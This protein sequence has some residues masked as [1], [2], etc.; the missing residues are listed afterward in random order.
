M[1]LL[2]INVLA[3][4]LAGGT[5][6]YTKVLYKRPEITEQK[7]RKKLVEKK[8]KK[9]N[10][11]TERG[12]IVFDPISINLKP[13]EGVLHYVNFKMVLE[14]F[15]ASQRDLLVTL[16]PLILDGVI[17]H[18]GRLSY[19]DL[20][21]VQGRFV[22]KNKIIDLANKAASERKI[23]EVAFSDVYFESFLIQ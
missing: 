9:K 6:F 3:T 13:E 19:S 2:L 12:I 11:E 10:L 15:D 5:L 22:L 16:K 17:D 1:V 21:T 20:V 14:I 23:S 18:I 4:A 7:E 8:E